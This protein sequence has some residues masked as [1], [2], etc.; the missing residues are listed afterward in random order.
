[1]KIHLFLWII[2]TLAFYACKTNENKAILSSNVNKPLAAEVE[3]TKGY[4]AK[5]WILLHDSS[6][7]SARSCPENIWLF[8][9]GESQ[10]KYLELN[11]K[12]EN[13]KLVKAFDRAPF[14]GFDEEDCS[15]NTS[16]A[17]AFR[18]VNTCHQ[19]WVVGPKLIHQV[20]MHH[21]VGVFA[22]KISTGVTVSTEKVTQELQFINNNLI[23]YRYRIAGADELGYDCEYI[24]P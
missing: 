19:S 3:L 2:G 20:K 13:S 22:W 21:K 8:W 9:K 15:G 6:K 7:K 14:I 4:T 23:K 5:E 17:G 16:F 12:L 11:T 1:M 24:K 10:E 18:G